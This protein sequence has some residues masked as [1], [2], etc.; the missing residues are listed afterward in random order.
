MIER[1]NLKKNWNLKIGIPALLPG[2]Y[3]FSCYGY[4][5]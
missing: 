3:Q 5:G 1:E 2:T 4:T